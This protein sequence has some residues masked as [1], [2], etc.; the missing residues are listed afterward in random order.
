MTDTDAIADLTAAV[1]EL[2]ARLADRAPE[3]LTYSIEEAAERLGPVCSVGWLRKHLHTVPHI[4]SGRG[5]G[6]AGR[7]AF[8]GAHLIEIVAM[9][10]VRPDDS[11]LPNPEDLAVVTRRSRRNVRD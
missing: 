6:R 5:R 4:R 10:E 9:L 11:S 7:L 1:R 8:T 2:T 3:R